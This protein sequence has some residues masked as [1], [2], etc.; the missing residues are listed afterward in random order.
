MGF[1]TTNVLPPI[2]G[3]NSHTAI[4]DPT[5]F[6]AQKEAL[7]LWIFKMLKL[8]GIT[9]YDLATSLLRSWKPEE[10]LA[11]AYNPDLIEPDDDGDGDE[12]TEDDD[13]D[14]GFS[15][16]TPAPLSRQLS[17]LSGDESESSS[18]P[19]GLIAERTAPTVKR[20]ERIVSDL[21]FEVVGLGLENSSKLTY[22]H[23]GSVDSDN[24]YDVTNPQ[25]WRPE[26]DDDQSVMQAESVEPQSDPEED[27]EET[28]EFPYTKV[29]KALESFDQWDFAI[30]G[31]ADGPFLST[32]HDAPMDSLDDLVE[33]TEAPAEEEKLE[34]GDL[35]D[36]LEDMWR[37]H[38]LNGEDNFLSGLGARLDEVDLGNLKARM[39]ETLEEDADQQHYS[40][41]GPVGGSGEDQFPDG[42]VQQRSR[43]G[44]GASHASF[45][46]GTQ[47]ML[48]KRIFFSLREDSDDEIE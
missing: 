26:V 42:P 27:D 43:S 21:Q 39:E 46:H 41:G 30:H 1:E 29:E 7:T 36:L 40:N 19:A 3:Q 22:G 45:I 35:V 17:R 24:E 16:G 33:S 9:D 34:A 28:L 13:S 4:L 44:I 48:S 25:S 12:E 5:S 2:P 8:W 38:H 23:F 31:T 11:I 10:I 6:A 14:H 15:L 47:S 37:G 18:V 32:M 20:R